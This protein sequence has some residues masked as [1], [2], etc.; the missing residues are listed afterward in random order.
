MFRYRPKF[1]IFKR[2]KKIFTNS[3][4]LNPKKPIRYGYMFKQQRL[5][6]R[7]RVDPEILK[8]NTRLPRLPRKRKTPFGKA[9][10]I[11][12]KFVYLLGGFTATTLANIIRNNRKGSFIGR[13]DKIVR[14]IETR[15]EIFM[16]KTNFLEPGIPSRD[17]IRKGYVFVNGNKISQP[18][19]N[20]KVTDVVEFRPPS[21]IRSKFLS[22]LL[23][24]YNKGLLFKPYTSC[25]I[26]N[27]K[28]I[29]SILFKIPKL[30]YKVFYPF[31]FRLANFLVLYSR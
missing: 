1:S 20:I 26:T 13:N 28:I 16:Y 21:F 3:V 8:I 25:V 29:S 12:Q 27:Y 10:E 14:D 22:R 2:Y 23:T 4:F 19:Y 30:R 15:L 9:L 17:A 24:L 7:R 5:Y 6:R 11:K 18:S 31:R